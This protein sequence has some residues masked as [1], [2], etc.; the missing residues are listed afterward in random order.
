MVAWKC[1]N[2]IG[3]YLAWMFIVT[4]TAFSALSAI[5][6][7]LQAKWAHIWF[8]ELIKN[9]F[10]SNFCKDKHEFNCFQQSHLFYIDTLWLK[11]LLTQR[12]L[13][14]LTIQM[15]LFLEFVLNYLKNLGKIKNQGS[16][17]VNSIHFYDFLNKN[18]M[19]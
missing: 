18:Q 8:F 19:Q 15:E 6:E 5:F 10:Q 9:Y 11:L 2:R 13:W 17:K 1:Q 12:L 4:S 3:A 14:Y 7:S 16:K